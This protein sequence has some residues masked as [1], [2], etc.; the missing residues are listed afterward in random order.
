MTQFSKEYSLRQAIGQ[1][2]ELHDQPTSVESP[3]ALSQWPWN[4]SA[5]GFLCQEYSPAISHGESGEG[6]ACEMT[7]AVV[8]VGHRQSKFQSR[9]AGMEEWLYI[10]GALSQ[11]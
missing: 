9:K 11:S 2:Y 7:G 10:P 1:A 8:H 3:L 4:V 5:G 6:S